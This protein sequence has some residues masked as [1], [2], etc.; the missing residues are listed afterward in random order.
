MRTPTGKTGIRC[1]CRRGRK[2]RG[3]GDRSARSGPGPTGTST[4]PTWPGQAQPV[5]GGARWRWGGETRFAGGDAAPAAAGW[6]GEAPYDVIFIDG[7]VE[8]VPAALFAQLKEGGRLIA[9]VGYN[10]AAPAMVYTR[11]ADDIGGR[12]E[13]DAFAPALPGFEKPRAFVF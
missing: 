5:G 8:E 3:A 6:P 7:A 13:F 9:V 11:T 1:A 10:R 2:V 4:R 12:P